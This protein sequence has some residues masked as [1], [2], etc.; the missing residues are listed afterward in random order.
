MLLTIIKTIIVFWYHWNELTP[1]WT[2]PKK[3][4]SYPFSK[5]N[6]GREGRQKTSSITPQNQRSYPATTIGVPYRS[7]SPHFTFVT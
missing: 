7:L 6:T 5:K 2:Q 3:S 1:R 4:V